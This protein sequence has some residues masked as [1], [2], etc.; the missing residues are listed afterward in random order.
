VSHIS[1]ISVEVKDIPSL[2]IACQELGLEFR[3]NQATYKWWGH[4]VGDSP[5]PEGFTEEDLGKC[6]HAAGISGNKTSYEVGVV[7]NKNGIGYQL[8][9]DSWAGGQGLEEVIGKDACKLKQAY[10]SA[11]AIKIASKT[12]NLVNQYIKSDGSRVYEFMPK[13]KF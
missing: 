4:Y 13:G 3:E 8:M 10:A 5:L 7:R 2:K 9:Y 11:V 1:T 6:E 12:S